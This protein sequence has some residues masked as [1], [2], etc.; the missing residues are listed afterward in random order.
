MTGV[1][2]VRVM[3]AACEETEMTF[4]NLAGSACGSWQP[5]HGLLLSG[6]LFCMS[7]EL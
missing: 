7:V 3:G 2:H 6:S 4:L 5:S 1:A